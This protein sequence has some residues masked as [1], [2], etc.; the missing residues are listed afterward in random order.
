[1]DNSKADNGKRELQDLHMD[2]VY[3]SQ[4]VRFE[5]Y[6]GQEKEVRLPETVEGLPL[7]VIGAKA[8][9][10]C[11]SVEHLVLPRTIRAVEDWGFAHMKQLKEIV[12]PAEEVAF[13]RKV[14]LGCDCLKRVCLSGVNKEEFYEGIPYFLAA[15][16]RFFPE[17]TLQSLRTAGMEETLHPNLPDGYGDSI[18]QE[19]SDGYG[20]NILQD[21]HLAGDVQGQ[22]KWLA[23]YDMA[24]SAFI[25]RNDDDGFEPAFI[26]WFDVEDVDDQRQEYIGRRREDKVLLVFLRLLYQ[27]ALQEDTEAV[28][29][30]Y[31]RDN[32]AFI[33]ELFLRN[34][35]C[36]R[37]IRY[38][39]IWKMSGGFRREYAQRLMD[40]LSEEEP[41]IRSYLLESQLEEMPSGDSFF[42]EL[43]L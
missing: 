31:L 22:W 16:F 37:D 14:F 8:F 2:F 30:Q 32:S 23:V 17:E 36:G 25:R 6:T 26:G 21:L 7:T 4:D 24:L 42:Q 5:K 13:G 33:A 34:K 11:K 19:L 18:L 3:G 20:E 41:E 35:T 43:E 15:A 1:M 28:L 10:S 39:K 29:K 38:Y 12:L 9:L 27:K 40:A